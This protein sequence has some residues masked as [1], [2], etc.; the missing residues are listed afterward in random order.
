MI[1]PLYA[2]WQACIAIYAQQSAFDKIVKVGPDT[3]GLKRINNTLTVTPLGTVDA[4]MWASNFEV[5]P[6]TD[7]VW[8]EMHTGFLSSGRAIAD[9]IAP[10][11][12]QAVADGLDV[13]FDGHSRGGSL[14]DVLASEF[15]LRGVKVTVFMFEA[16]P[17][18]KIQYV[19]W[20]AAQAKAGMITVGISTVNGIDPVPYSDDLLGY[21]ATYPRKNL[22]HAPGGLED[23][24]SIDWHSGTTI[25]A[26]MQRI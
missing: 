19:D 18:G 5:L 17:I 3:I 22:D 26:G 15:A 23:L 21:M 13:V 2:A 10:D 11:V 16:A 20:C 6:T 4:A 9:T 25:Y 14:A 1:S 12:M 24:D 7:P 8:G